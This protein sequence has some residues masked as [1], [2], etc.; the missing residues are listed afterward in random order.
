F[1]TNYMTSSVQTF[2]PQVGVATQKKKFNFSA[3]A[4]T[5]IYKYKAFS[6]YLSE[7]TTL[8]RNEVHPS[9]N[10]W[11][12]YNF[13]KS[14]SMWVNYRYDVSFPSAQ[15]ILAVEDLSSPL[16]TIVGNPDISPNKRH[17]FYL[18]FRDYDYASTSGYS[19]YAG[20]QCSDDGVTMSTTFDASRRGITTYENAAGTN[21]FW[22]GGSWSKSIKRD[23][24][25]YRL[26]LGINSD[27]SR[28]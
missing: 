21:S 10:L 5:A 18:S 14:M 11:G 9:G 12:G 15:Q 2:N 4:G 7:K 16:N 6:D 20:G 1:L 19:F 3:Y 25:T 24:H 8:R 13:T 23:A 17:H 28:T 22:C 27:F 26:A